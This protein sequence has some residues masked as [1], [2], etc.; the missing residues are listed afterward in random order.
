LASAPEA[1]QKL[2]SRGKRVAVGEERS[3]AARGCAAWAGRV[4]G[5]D[6]SNAQPPATP[7][8][9]QTTASAPQGPPGSAGFGLS[10]TQGNS[11]TLNI[12]ATVDSTYDPKT[13][14]AMKW[15]ALFLRGTENGTLSVNRLA[16][17][18]R[19]ENTVNGR[20]F[21]FG[22]FDTLHDT[23]KGIDY[24]YAPPPASATRPSCRNRRR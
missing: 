7:V 4:Y 2:F 18:F 15:S 16:A 13:G 20:M 22:Q 11:D 24:L 8:A 17:M 5:E 10:L 21:V 14:N 9:Q 12:S 3:L 23:F 1:L 6:G 19:D